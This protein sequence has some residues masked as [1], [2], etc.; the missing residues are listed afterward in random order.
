MH[1]CL[2]VH[3]CF[4]FLFSRGFSC[5]TFVHV[6]FEQ[7]SFFLVRRFFFPH[8][9]YFSKRRHSRDFFPST[10]FFILCSPV[11]GKNT[12]LEFY[13]KSV[14][15]DLNMKDLVG[16]TPIMYAIAGN[17]KNSVKL[18]VESGANL[19]DTDKSSFF[20]F[21]H[22]IFFLDPMMKKIL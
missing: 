9:F 19:S 16:M 10:C 3:L 13:L 1:V 11:S 8:R 5:V 4:L 17:R 14:N 6:C 20:F 15:Y 7:V 2:P 21:L 12:F 22:V 18:L